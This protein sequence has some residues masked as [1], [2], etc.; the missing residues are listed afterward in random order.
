MEEEA[1]IAELVNSEEGVHQELVSPIVTHTPVPLASLPVT[2][3]TKPAPSYVRITTPMIG[4]AHVLVISFNNRIT[5]SSSPHSKCS[6]CQ[7]VLYLE[8]A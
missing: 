6:T 5:C 1:A 2:D 8:H 4:T 3:V 7:M